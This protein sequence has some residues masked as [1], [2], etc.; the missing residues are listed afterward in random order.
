MH[1]KGMALNRFNYS[2][3]IENKEFAV[4]KQEA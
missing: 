4:E 1:R 3:M 2:R